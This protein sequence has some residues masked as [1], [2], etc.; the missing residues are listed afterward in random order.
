MFVRNRTG[1]H[2]PPGV[3][4]LRDDDRL[5][6]IKV[7]SGDSWVVDADLVAPDG[8]PASPKNSYVEFVLSE[9]QFS[10]PIWTG[11]WVNGILPD[12]NIK[13]LVHIRIPGE[14]TKSLRR[15]SYMFSVRVSDKMKFYFSTQ[16]KGNFLVEY[17]PTS[18]QRS[19]PYRDGTSEIFTGSQQQAPGGKQPSTDTDEEI[20]RLKAEIRALRKALEG[21]ADADS[22]YSKDETTALVSDGVSQAITDIVAGAPTALDTLKEIADWIGN[23]HSGATQV[24]A[25]KVDKVQGMGLSHNDYTDSDKEKVDGLKS[26]ATSGSYNDLTDKPTI[27]AAQVNADWNAQSGVAQILNKPTIP[28]SPVNADWN[29]QSGLAQILNKPTKLSSFTNNGDGNSPFA[30]I[31]ETS[32]L[33][34]NVPSGNVLKDR[35]ANYVSVS[36]DTVLTLPRVVSGRSR[37]FIVRVSVGGE[38]VPSISFSAYAGE[39]VRYETDGESFPKPDAIGTWIYAFSETAVGVFLVALKSVQEVSQDEEEQAEEE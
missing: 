10:P 4:G 7:V 39:S 38:T 27:P 28:A 23:D 8:G 9:N 34:Y 33:I 18:D 24:I 30:T 35:A 13:G 6:V 29:A 14:L 2:L 20:D 15:G 22:V 32:Y 19:I 17:M 26:V 36:S 3:N 11:E 16:L 21:K 5:P 37:D 12:E 31:D 25:G 1:S